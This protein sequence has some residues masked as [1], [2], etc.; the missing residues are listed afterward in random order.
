MNYTEARQEFIQT[1]G[2]L[3]SQWGISKTMAQI[4]A[5]LLSSEEA[6]TTDQIMED[7]M[8]SRGNANMNV[9]T[10]VDWGLAIKCSKT[11][12]RMDFYMA[13]KDVHS[14]GPKIA[15]ER[16]KREL[17]PVLIALNKLSQFED[18][19]TEEKEGFKKILNE[20]NDFAKLGDQLLKRYVESERGW[21][22][23]VLA[24]WFS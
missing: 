8:I 4:H 18:D 24:K 16:R 13:D 1:W 5:Y 10:L 22:T 2:S 17:E 11:G 19:R 20:I 9:R 7:L 12:E 3:G 15:R 21:F 23:R 6:V 14:F